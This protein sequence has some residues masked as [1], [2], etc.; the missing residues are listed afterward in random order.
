MT[1]CRVRTPGPIPGPI[2]RTEFK[3]NSS[4]RL[5][6]CGDG[7]PVDPLIQ[8]VDVSVLNLDFLHN[9]ESG[10]LTARLSLWFGDATP[11][12]V[13]VGLFQDTDALEPV[14]PNNF[15]EPAGAL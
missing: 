5:Y 6:F 13:G 4:I 3:G 1:V 15:L 11:T 10:G 12:Q 7:T 8:G 2:L 9:I 14:E